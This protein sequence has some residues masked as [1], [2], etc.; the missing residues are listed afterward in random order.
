M[1]GSG[2]RVEVVRSSR[3]TRTVSARRDG[4][5]TVVLVPA[6]LTAA[7][8]S[9]WVATMLERLARQEARR[10]PRDADLEQRAAMLSARHLE[11]RARPA[12]VRWSGRQ[13]S[14]WG[15]C[16]PADGTIRLSSRLQG[17]PGWVVDYVLVHELAHLLQAGHDRAFWDLV[18]RY[19]QCER[20]RGYLQG[21]TAAAGLDL[22]DD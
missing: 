10:R 18:S 6:R 3:R 11:G 21:V 2:D 8:E 16:T 4:D 15:S 9:R 14:R 20:A 5:R 17:M 19:P 7:E 12:S 22:S 13:G 1:P